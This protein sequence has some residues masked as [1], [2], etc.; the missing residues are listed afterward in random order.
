MELNIYLTSNKMEKLRS[1][2]VTPT[3]YN[4]ATTTNKGILS[5]I[6]TNWSLYKEL[7]IPSW[8]TFLIRIWKACYQ[9]HIWFLCLKPDNPTISTEQSLEIANK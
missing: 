7:E 2:E 6:I 1:W 3:S 5:P 9:I 4:A 8:K